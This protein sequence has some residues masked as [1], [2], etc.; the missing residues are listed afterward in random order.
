MDMTEAIKVTI[1]L[2]RLLNDLGIDRDLLK[3]NCDSMISIYLVKNQM[4]HVKM[5]HINIRLHFVW[6]IPDEGGLSYG[7]FTRKRIPPMCLPRLF[8]E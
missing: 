2:Q 3:I 6:E 5:K 4:Y 7:R 1:W 8:R